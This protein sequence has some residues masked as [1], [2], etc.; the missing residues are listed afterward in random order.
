MVKSIGVDWVLAG[1]SERREIFG[2]TDDYI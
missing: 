1:H 2:E